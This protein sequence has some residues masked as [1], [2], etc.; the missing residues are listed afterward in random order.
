MQA[1]CACIRLQLPLRPG[2]SQVGERLARYDVE[3][4]CAIE[5]EDYDL[6]KKKKELMDEYRRTVFQQ[7]EVHNLLD[8]TL[9]SSQLLMLLQLYFL[10][11][12]TVMKQTHYQLKFSDK[13]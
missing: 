8:V 7:L 2:I 13:Q 6:A 12:K 4:R 5:K 3:K 1:H 11:H 10:S 9:V